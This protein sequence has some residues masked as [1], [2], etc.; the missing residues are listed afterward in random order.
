MAHIAFV[1]EHASVSGTINHRQKQILRALEEIMLKQGRPRAALALSV[2]PILALAG[3]G[4]AAEEGNGDDIFAGEQIRFIVPTAAGGGFD[5]VAR[6]I[7][8]YLEDELNA[9]LVVENLEGGNY[10]VGTEELVENGDDCTT[11]MMLASP[12]INFS[13]LTQNVGYSL[14]DL[15]AAGGVTTEPGIWRVHNDAEWD[16]MEELIED[17]RSRPG[18]ITVSVSNYATSNYLGV[19]NLQEA[20]DI[21]FNVVPFDGGS[22]ARQ[23]L[24]SQEVDVN[25]AG[26]FNSLPAAEDTRALAV[27][28][29]ENLWPDQTNDAPALSDVVEGVESDGSEY[30]VWTNATCAEENSEAFD[31]LAEAVENVTEDQEFLDEVA[32]AGEEGKVQHMSPDDFMDYARGQ[33]EEIENI[34]EEEPDLFG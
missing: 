8:P 3:C 32:E 20:A 5:T 25:Q 23:A 11:V 22:P 12:H 6:Q 19:L 15:A 13:Y 17:A 4:D 33:D 29:P 24:L 2:V 10:A 21:E 34:M 27:S 26:V 18:E 1:N 30:A 14:D 7:G 31:R 16:D 28:Q 9:R